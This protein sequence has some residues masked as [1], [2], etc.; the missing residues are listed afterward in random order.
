M[1][2]QSPFIDV[3][4]KRFARA[5]QRLTPPSPRPLPRSYR[6]EAWS[7]KGVTQ[8]RVSTGKKVFVSQ[9]FFLRLTH[10]CRAVRFAE[11]Y[12]NPSFR[13]LISDTYSMVHRG[14]P[15]SHP[16]GSSA[17]SG[18]PGSALNIPTFC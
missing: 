12:S 18:R 10:Y 3:V 14:D 8:G 6:G 16:S 7:D 1:R 11:R 15:F 2:K 5:R 17:G 13:R 9:F 4:V